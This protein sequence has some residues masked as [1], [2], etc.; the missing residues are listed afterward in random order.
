MYQP[1]ALPCHSDPPRAL[2]PHA[3]LILPCHHLLTEIALP[4]VEVLAVHA[5]QQRIEHRLCLLVYIVEVIAIDECTSFA[6]MGMQVKVEIELGRLGEVTAQ[7]LG[8]EFCFA[9]GVIV[10]LKLA[11]YLFDCIDRGLLGEIRVI[12][13]PIQVLAKGVKPKMTPCHTIWIKHGHNLYSEVIQYRHQ[14][15]ISLCLSSP[16]I[17]SLTIPWLSYLRYILSTS[18][19]TQKLQYSAHNMGPWYFPGMYPCTYEYYR[20]P[21][22]VWSDHSCSCI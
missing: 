6:G 19:T 21:R 7:G 9:E 2:P 1:R 4:E 12:V 3:L 5:Y 18:T 10:F 14:S 11:D 17:I 13:M 16:T 8:E 20:L 15:G 22:F